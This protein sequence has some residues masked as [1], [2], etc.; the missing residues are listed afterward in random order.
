MTLKIFNKSD[1]K[2]IA[3]LENSQEDM[4]HQEK[5]RNSA[6]KHIGLAAGLYAGCLGLAGLLATR[7]KNSKIL[8]KISEFIV[9]PGN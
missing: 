2:N 8:Q 4:K 5:V 3:S 6:K 7:G 1:F 9:A